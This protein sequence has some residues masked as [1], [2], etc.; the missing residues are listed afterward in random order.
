MYVC[1]FDKETSRQA[2]EREREREDDK[3]LA[4]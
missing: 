3:A 1:M 2:D 4:S